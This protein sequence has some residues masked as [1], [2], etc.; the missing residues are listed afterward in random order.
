MTF[1]DEATQTA[2]VVFVSAGAAM[3]AVLLDWWY[4]RNHDLPHGGD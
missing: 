1:A 4:R 3:L 2:L